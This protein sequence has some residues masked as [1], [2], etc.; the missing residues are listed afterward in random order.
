MTG[1]YAYNAW[2]L[3][4]SAAHVV[5]TPNVSYTTDSRSGLLSRTASGPPTRRR[6]GRVFNRRPPDRRRGA[7]WTDPLDDPRRG[8][9]LPGRPQE[10]VLAQC[11][12]IR[13]QDRRD[14]HSARPCANSK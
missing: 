14:C 2:G 1:N 6:A 7:A 4:T 9:R 11:K 12:A 8:G 13:G 5:G 10:E 3:L